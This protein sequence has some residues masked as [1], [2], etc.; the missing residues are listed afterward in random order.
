MYYLNGEVLNKEP[1]DESIFY[2]KSLFE[3][4]AVINSKALFLNEHLDRLFLSSNKLK[5]NIQGNLKELVL[6]FISKY[7]STNEEMLKILV[8]NNKLYMKLL[9]FKLRD[10]PN[11]TKAMLIKN[12]FQNEMGMYKS[13]NYLSNILA[14]EEVVEGGYF[15]G[16]FTN[17]LGQ[18]CE[19]TISNIFFIKDNIIY[20]PHLSLNILSGITRKLIIDLALASDFLVQEGFF[21]EEDLKNSDGI[22]FTNSLM[23]KG[24]IWICEF[25]EKKFKKHEII[26][27]LENKYLKIQGDML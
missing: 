3:T 16:V 2:G 18:I 4:I 12:Y 8:S 9:P 1:Y 21:F 11:G 26:H 13:A 19:G 24:L 25:K 15:E 6:N 20:T 14:R 23:K 27:I 5:I 10:F 17:R 7:S 22:F